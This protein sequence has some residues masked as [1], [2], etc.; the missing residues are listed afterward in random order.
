MFP[1]LLAACAPPGGPLQAEID[2]Y[3]PPR[4]VDEDRDQ[5]GILDLD[6]EWLGTLADEPDTDGDDLADGDELLL[7]TDPVAADTDLDGLEDGEEVELG[8]DPA[9]PD[10]DG[11]GTPDGAE[12]ADGTSPDDPRDDLLTGTFGGGGGCAH[13]LP[14]AGVPLG[15]L[16]WL[17]GLFAA[18]RPGNGPLPLWDRVEVRAAGRGAR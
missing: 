17:A 5:D 7:G 16:A 3:V 15:L 10:T 4:G 6:E 8:S 13:A 2:V 1:L 18:V 11:G 9:D 14:A 12:I